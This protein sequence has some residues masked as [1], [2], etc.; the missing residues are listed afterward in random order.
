[1]PPPTPTTLSYLWRGAVRPWLFICLCFQS[2][3]L[4]LM[5]SL[6][7]KKQ[8]QQSQTFTGVANY[9]WICNWKKCLL[10]NSLLNSVLFM[11]RQFCKISFTLASI[12]T[13]LNINDRVISCSFSKIV[14]ICFMAN[15]GSFS[16]EILSIPQIQGGQLLWRSYYLLL[17]SLITS[18]IFLVWLKSSPNNTES[19]IK[20]VFRT[21]FMKKSLEPP[22]T[23]PRNT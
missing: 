21:Q 1:M 12:W 2:I 6:F 14:F 4:V 3:P 22:A 8:G 16:S 20:W 13:G 10:N 7:P 15:Q 9:M 19:T 18:V 5:W 23:C 17:V 11:Y